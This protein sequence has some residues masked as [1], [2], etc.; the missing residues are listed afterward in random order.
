M[1]RQRP[2]HDA[3]CSF[4]AQAELLAEALDA[5]TEWMAAA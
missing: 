3:T 4:Q 1:E 5:M 2:H